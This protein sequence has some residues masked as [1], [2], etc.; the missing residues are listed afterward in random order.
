MEEDPIGIKC[1]LLGESGTGKSSLIERFINK[2]RLFYKYLYI[3]ILLY[4]LRIF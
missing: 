3:N 2:L 4:V 1:V